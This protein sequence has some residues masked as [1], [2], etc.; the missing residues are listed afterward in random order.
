[1]CLTLHFRSIQKSFEVKCIQLKDYKTLR[2]EKEE[3]RRCSKSFGRICLLN[4]NENL[5]VMR[6][7][8]DNFLKNSE[9]LATDISVPKKWS[10][11]NGM[12]KD[13]LAFLAFRK[14]I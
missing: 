11:L 3:F 12:L 5:S 1:M 2:K 9:A 6:G 4:L 10:F 7:F 8:I 14:L 13:F